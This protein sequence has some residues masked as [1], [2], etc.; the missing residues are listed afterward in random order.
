MRYDIPPPGF[1]ARNYTQLPKAKFSPQ[2][3]ELLFDFGASRP[4]GPCEW[5]NTSANSANPQLGRRPVA[6]G[7]LLS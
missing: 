3:R 2:A 7:K 4:P 5:R 6:G 1:I